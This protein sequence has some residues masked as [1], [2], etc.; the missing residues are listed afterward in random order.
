MIHVFT[1]GYDTR[2]GRTITTRSGGGLRPLSLQ[3]KPSTP[4]PVSGSSDSDNHDEVERGAYTPTSRSSSAPTFYALGGNVTPIPLSYPE[5]GPLTP[6]GGPLTSS[7]LL[8]T[9][10]KTLYR[11]RVVLRLLCIMGA[12]CVLG[13]LSHVTAVYIRTKDLPDDE[14]EDIWPT[15]GLDLIPTHMILAGAAV[16]LVAGMGWTGA[17]LIQG[18]RRLDASTDSWVKWIAG[19]SAAFEMTLW[20]IGIGYAGRVRNMSPE[21][22]APTL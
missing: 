10:E 1:D 22:N 14:G 13:V 4:R 3:Y 15:D 19:G 8:G 18:V 9:I 16:C 21:E 2:T 7:R 11:L 6:I 17:S 20:L 5:K 12:G